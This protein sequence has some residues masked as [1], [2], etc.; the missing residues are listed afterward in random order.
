LKNGKLSRDIY[1]TW[2][3]QVAGETKTYFIPLN[4]MIAVEY[5]KMDTVKLNSLFYGDHTHTS[6]EGAVLNAQKVAE[7]IK[8]LKGIKLK[9][10]LL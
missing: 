1:A 9:K 2:A 8:N 4:E 3:E 5:E 7:G 10:Y 6:K